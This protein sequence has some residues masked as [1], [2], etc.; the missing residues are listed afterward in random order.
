VRKKLLFTVWRNG[1]NPKPSTRSAKL[2]SRNLPHPADPRAFGA[3]FFSISMAGRSGRDAVLADVVF[4]RA[5]PWNFLSGAIVRIPELDKYHHQHHRSNH[6]ILLL[7]SLMIITIMII[8]TNNNN[9]CNNNKEKE[10]RC[11]QNNYGTTSNNNLAATSAKRKAPRNRNAGRRSRIRFCGR[12]ISVIPWN[13][14]QGN[15]FALKALAFDEEG[16]GDL[17]TP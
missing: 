1:G 3:L 17:S 10:R 11:I 13:I 2:T 15:N 14:R 9:K 7:L 8:N 12:P 5:T 6:V 4:G 16:W